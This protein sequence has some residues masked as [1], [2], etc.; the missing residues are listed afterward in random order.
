V[1]GKQAPQQHRCRPHR[2]RV[3][4]QL[5]DNDTSPLRQPRQGPVA[6]DAGCRLQDHLSRPHRRPAQHDE[7]WI[8]HVDRAD[9]PEPE[10]LAGLLQDASGQRIAGEARVYDGLHGDLVGFEPGQLPPA[11]ELERT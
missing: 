4:S 8:E 5:T 9:D 1:Y 2:P 11:R 6:H 7:F 10:V 3:L